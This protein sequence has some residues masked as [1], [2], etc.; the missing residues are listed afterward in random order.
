MTILVCIYTTHT[1]RMME[2]LGSGQ[3]GMVNK[4][5]WQSPQGEMEVAVKILKEGSDKID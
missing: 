1:N 4:A 2:S 5:T 3:F